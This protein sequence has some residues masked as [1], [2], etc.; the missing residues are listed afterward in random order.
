MLTNNYYANRHH[1]PVQKMFSV[2]KTLK[3]QLLMIGA[4]TIWIVVTKLPNVDHHSPKIIS[5]PLSEVSAILLGLT[6]VAFFYILLSAIL[7]NHREIRL[8]T[9]LVFLFLSGLLMAGL[10]THSTTAIIRDQLSKDDAVYQLVMDNLHRTWSHNMFQLGYYGLVLL[11]AWSEASRASAGM[12]KDVAQ[13]SNGV[14]KCEHSTPV[15]TSKS[16][17][18]VKKFENGISWTWSLVMASF[19]SKFAVQTATIPVTVLFGVTV[20]GGGGLWLAK[21]QP[22]HDESFGFLLS[23]C[24]PRTDLST[25]KLTARICLIGM[26][27]L[28]IIYCW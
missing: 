16:V 23:T 2:P 13:V 6:V 25:C 8:R 20:L 7:G 24:S 27:I 10:G 3:R 5:V 11:L 15:Y 9:H 28:P 21:M 14:S 19:Y 12:E 1:N 26:L 18:E 17:V 22:Y 4:N